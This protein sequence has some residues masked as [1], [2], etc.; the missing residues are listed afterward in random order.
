[1]LFGEP[2]SA[3]TAYFNASY[4]S[5]E[6]IMLFGEPNSA[7]S[8]DIVPSQQWIIDIRQ[9]KATSVDAIQ[10]QQWNIYTIQAKQHLLHI[11]MDRIKP[12]YISYFL[13]V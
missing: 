10:S 1:M 8:V 7:T 2:N 6:Y 9:A 5:N 4:K 11:S 3:T 13:N 12:M